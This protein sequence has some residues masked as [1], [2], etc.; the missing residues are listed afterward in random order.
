[1]EGKEKTIGLNGAPEGGG[2]K[3]R[4][5]GKKKKRQKK[6]NG[7]EISLPQPEKEGG[8]AVGKGTEL[9]GRK[10]REGKN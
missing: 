8:P 5:D 2:G 7:K 1:M 9:H 10:C 6:K 3:K 4:E